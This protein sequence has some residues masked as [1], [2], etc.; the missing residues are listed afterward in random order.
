MEKDNTGNSPISGS[1]SNHAESVA[2][3]VQIISANLLVEGHFRFQTFQEAMILSEF[4]AETCPNKML[5]HMGLAELFTNAV[6]HGNLGITS[7]E[8][9]TLQ[10]NGLWLEEI[11]L[12]LH[13]P[14]NQQKWVEV[15]VTRQDHELMVKVIDQ[16]VGFDWQKYQEQNEN[17]NLDTHGRGIVMAKDLAFKNLQYSGRGNVVT[18]IID[19]QKLSEH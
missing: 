6:E 15:F 2:R 4:I 13:L 5:S 12:R 11:E 8:K 7:E 1:V 19:L 16:G 17:L 10:K 14:E 9:A 18:G 3:Q